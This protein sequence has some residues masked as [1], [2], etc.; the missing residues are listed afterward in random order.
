MLIARCTAAICVAAM[1]PAAAQKDLSIT[2]ILTPK[3]DCALAATENVTVRIF[4]YGSSLQPGTSFMLTYT[5][6]AGGPITELAMLP[7]TFLSHGSLA[8]TFTTQANLF[9]SGSYIFAAT[10]SIAGDINPGNDAY[11]GY[12]VINSAPSVGGSVSGPAGPTFSGNVSL[13]GQTGN[14]LTWQQSDDGGL[15]WR[16]LANTSSVQS[17]D[18]LRE[19]TTFRVLLRNGLCASA[20][21]STHVVLSSDPIFYSGFEP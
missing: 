8:Y 16:R 10:V 9:S 18:Q 11:N 5:I 2:G 14:V 13:S 3:S 20:F 12:T 7:S 1:L 19:H 4:N 15:R 17:F 21:S 6:N